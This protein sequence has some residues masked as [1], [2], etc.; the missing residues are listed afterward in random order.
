LDKN[1]YA[2]HQLKFNVCNSAPGN[3][4]GSYLIVF[5]NYG[6]YYY[7]PTQAN[8]YHQLHLIK[9]EYRQCGDL[10]YTL[11]NILIDMIKNFN[12]NHYNFK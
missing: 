4:T 11:P 1:R 8:N 10:K 3:I 7:K 2:I 9:I 12:I 5:D 6:D